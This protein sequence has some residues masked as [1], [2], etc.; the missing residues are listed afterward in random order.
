MHYDVLYCLGWTKSVIPGHEQSRI[1]NVKVH[2]KLE[3]G[4]IE[5]FMKIE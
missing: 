5:S 3:T 2:V 4:G 1:P